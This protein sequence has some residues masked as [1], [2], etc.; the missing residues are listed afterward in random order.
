[1]KRKL[2][3]IR[4][5]RKACNKTETKENT[6]EKRNSKEKE[7]ISEA[8]ENILRDKENKIYKIRTRCYKKV[9]TEKEKALRKLKIS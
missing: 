3:I 7:T 1:M 9:F 4:H 2:W 8:K 5:L 6:Q